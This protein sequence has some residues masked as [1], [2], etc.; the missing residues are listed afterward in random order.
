MAKSRRLGKG[1]EAILSM[2]DTSVKT[3]EPAVETKKASAFDTSLDDDL[4]EMPK[5]AVS[6]KTLGEYMGEEPVSEETSGPTLVADKDRLQ[7]VPVDR[8]DANPWQPRTTFDPKEIQLLAESLKTHGLIQPIMLRPNADRFQLIAGERRFRAAVRL[9]WKE[10]VARVVEA[11]DRQMSEIALIENLDRKDLN[12]IEKAVSFQNYLEQNQCT[13]KE[14][15]DRLGIDRSTIANFIRLLDLPKEVQ[16]YLCDGSICEGHARGLLRLAK[17]QDQL[18]LAERIANESLSVRQVEV[19]VNE[20]NEEHPAEF[21]PLTPERGF[22]DGPSIKQKAAP[23]RES[24]SRKKSPQI[25]DLERQFR[26][27]LGLKV[28]LVANERGKGRMEIFF[29][30]QDE[31]NDLLEY[32]R[33]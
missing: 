31:F 2:D 19:M 29:R 17:K 28:N 12:P 1:L 32:F 27:A 21:A 15:G 16:K 11:N 14:L 30:N 18:D 26:E 25:L 23:D 33:E 10:V 6:H 5:A 24:R 4:F 8:I 3:E 22:R 20:W 7:Y 9:G 13:Q